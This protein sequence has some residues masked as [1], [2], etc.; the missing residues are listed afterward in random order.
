MC[1]PILDEN[2]KKIPCYPAHSKVHSIQDIRSQ[3]KRKN[4]K[5]FFWLEKK[6]VVY[7]VVNSNYSEC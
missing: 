4:E 7:M 3:D 1:T 6:Y 5:S 2:F